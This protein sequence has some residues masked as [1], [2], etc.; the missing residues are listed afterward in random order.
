[1]NAKYP[2]EITKCAKAVLAVAGRILNHGN[3]ISVPLIQRKGVGE[4]IEKKATELIALGQQI[5]KL[6]K[7]F[8][9]EK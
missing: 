5:K 2:I 8:A 1:M 7:E 9:R 6:A 3:L 4:D